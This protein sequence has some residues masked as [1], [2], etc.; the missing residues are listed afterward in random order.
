MANSHLLALVLKNELVPTDFST[1]N[2]PLG[3]KVGFPDTCRYPSI[4]NN[5][6]VSLIEIAG[7]SNDDR[8]RETRRCADL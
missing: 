2:F 3:R 6:P 5:R 7:T 1:V 4:G 8:V